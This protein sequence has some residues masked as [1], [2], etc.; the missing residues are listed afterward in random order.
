MERLRSLE[1]LVSD[2]SGQL[3]ESQSQLQSQSHQARTVPP[4]SLASSVHRATGP[5]D[6]DVGTNGVQQRM[7]SLAIEQPQPQQATTPSNFWTR[8]NE[9]VGYLT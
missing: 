6:V 8:I 9:E 5:G 4:P 7:R 2:L 1:T 3:A